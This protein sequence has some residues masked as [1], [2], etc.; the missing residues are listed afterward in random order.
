ME[1][2]PCTVGKENLEYYVFNVLG[3]LDLVDYE[4]PKYHRFNTSGRIMFFSKIVFKEEI[5]VPLFGISDL[6]YA[7]FFCTEKL[8]TVLDRLD[9]QGL[10]LSSDLF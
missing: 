6:R 2:L 10:R 9:V 5:T 3:R 8:K 1:F 7:S 4:K